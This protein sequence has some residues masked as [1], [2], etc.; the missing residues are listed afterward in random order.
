MRLHGHYRVKARGSLLVSAVHSS[1]IC[2]QCGIH[3]PPYTQGTLDT[4]LYIMEWNF[5]CKM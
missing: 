2:L 1:L 5:L 4:D 3:N